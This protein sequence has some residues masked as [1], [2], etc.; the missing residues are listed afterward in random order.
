MVGTNKAC[1]IET[2][3]AMLE[4]LPQTVPVPDQ[5]ADPAALVELLRSRG[6]RPIRFTDCPKIDAIERERGA[7]QGRPRVKMIT[8]EE[9]FAALDAE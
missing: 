3:A 6:V 8:A 9:M 4:D 7:A 5:R 1:A 2:V